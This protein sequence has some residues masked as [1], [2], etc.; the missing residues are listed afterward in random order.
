M[1]LDPAAPLPTNGILCWLV[2]VIAGHLPVRPDVLL[3][4]FSAPSSLSSYSPS[5]LSSANSVS[6]HKPWTSMNC[7]WM[8]TR[9]RGKTKTPRRTAGTL[10]S[11][12]LVCHFLVLYWLMEHLLL[13]TTTC[14]CFFIF[15]SVCI[16]DTV[17]N[18]R[19][20][21]KIRRQQLVDLCARYNLTR[22]GN[23]TSL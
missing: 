10:K 12:L 16:A 2:L 21:R 13:S 7:Q 19:D 8:L 9:R 5:S 3:P 17:K 11:E 22:S 20:D 15:F 6:E 1:L 14:K 4:P 18:P 23:M